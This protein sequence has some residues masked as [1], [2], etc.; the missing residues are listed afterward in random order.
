MAFE[1]FPN[2]LLT[3]GF[4][5]GV[6]RSV[7]GLRITGWESEDRAAPNRGPEGE[8]KMK[9]II[10]RG[11]SLIFLAIAIASSAQAADVIADC[12]AIAEKEIKAAQHPLPVTSVE[13][14]MVHIA[15]YDA[16]EAIDQ[17]YE[18]YHAFV[19]GATGSMSTAAAKAGRDVLVGLFPGQNASI[20]QDYADP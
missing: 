19:P 1:L 6:K 9:K 12:N 3:F 11:S 7:S 10:E 20:D 4:K 17:R 8:T 2:D 16:V 14:A 13:F 18:P 5:F 15:I